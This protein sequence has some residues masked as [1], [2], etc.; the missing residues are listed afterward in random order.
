MAAHEEHAIVVVL[1]DGRE[2]AI[3][4]VAELGRPDLSAVD[5]IARL[6]LAVRRQGWKIRLTGTCGELGELLDLAGLSEAV[7]RQGPLTDDS[8]SPGQQ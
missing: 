7:G 1:G 3:A 2:V 5:A 4:R 6:Q 8:E